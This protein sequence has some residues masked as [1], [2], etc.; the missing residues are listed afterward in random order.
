MPAAEERERA[1]A[2]PD[3]NKKQELNQTKLTLSK[4]SVPY[5]EVLGPSGSG[6]V[7]PSYVYGSGSFHYQAKILRKI[8]IFPLFCDFFIIFHLRRMM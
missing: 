2:I 5:P 7:S 6:S 8:C 1:G 3:N 4:S